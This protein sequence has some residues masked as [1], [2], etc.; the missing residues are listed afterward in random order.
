MVIKSEGIVGPERGLYRLQSDRIL[1]VSEWVY[2][3]RLQPALF[4]LASCCGCLLFGGLGRILPEIVVRLV[5]NAF[6]PIKYGI[7]FNSF[8][9]IIVLNICTISTWL[10][11]L[12]NASSPYIHNLWS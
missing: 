8:R 6:V 4:R 11:F 3:G 7:N 2:L 1:Y 10:G 9:Y 12:Y 5:Q